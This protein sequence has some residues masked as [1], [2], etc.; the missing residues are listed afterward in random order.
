[1]IIEHATEL[2]AC[3]KDLATSVSG[4]ARIGSGEIEQL[5]RAVDREL[6]SIGAALLP[7]AERAFDLASDVS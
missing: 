1:L 5:E 4:P 6:E 7:C 2:L 3:A